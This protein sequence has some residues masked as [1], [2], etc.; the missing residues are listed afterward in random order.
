[1]T[2]TFVIEDK[3][4]TPKELLRQ[5][6]VSS[7]LTLDTGNLTSKLPIHAPGHQL[8]NC[9]YERGLTNAAPGAVCTAALNPV[10]KVHATWKRFDRPEGTSPS[11]LQEMDRDLNACDVQVIDEIGL[12]STLR[13]N[14]SKLAN[15][16]HEPLPGI[17][18]HNRS[19]FFEGRA[20]PGRSC[21]NI[22]MNHFCSSKSV[23]AQHVLSDSNPSGLSNTFVGLGSSSDS[24]SKACITFLLTN[25][26]SRSQA[27]SSEQSGQDSVPMFHVGRKSDGVVPAIWIHTED[28]SFKDSHI[29]RTG[30]NIHLPYKDWTVSFLQIFG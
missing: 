6:D 4:V 24:E 1:M 8:E 18:G 20:V 14:E 9:H 2:N 16:I 30:K 27:S 19:S 3:V 15:R 7:S 25:A 29:K 13:S 5:I 17:R 11:D 23:F 21:S 26:Q 22:R 28:L 10:P 12:A